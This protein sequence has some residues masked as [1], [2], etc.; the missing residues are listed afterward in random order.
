VKIVGIG[1][2]RGL[3]DNV[4][5]GV[6]SCV[7]FGEICFVNKSLLDQ[8]LERLHE[9][10]IFDAEVKN[11]DLPGRPEGPE[12]GVCVQVSALR[13]WTHPLVIC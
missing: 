2:C 13:I 11:S 6:F 10:R 5:Q 4:L 9:C 3:V 7:V 8:R 12:G 1:G